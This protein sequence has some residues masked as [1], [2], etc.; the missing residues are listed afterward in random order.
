MIRPPFAGTMPHN[1]PPM[2]RALAA[3]LALA[4]LLPA[5]AFAS[6]RD[7]PASSPHATAVKVLEQLEVVGGFGDGSFRPAARVTRAEYLKMLYRSASRS[8]EQ[9]LVDDT[10]TP[11][12]TDVPEDAWYAPYVRSAYQRG[13]AH[14]V[15]DTLFAPDRGV[16]LYEAARMLVALEF[17]GIGLIE[18][19]APAGDED[20]ARAN[21]DAWVR[22]R[23]LVRA[24]LSGD[25]PLTRGDVADLLY[26]WMVVKK[27][28]SSG[29]D[30]ALD[31]KLRVVPVAVPDEQVGELESFKEAL[32]LIES[33]Y[34]DGRNFPSSGAIESGIHGVVDGLGD[35][36]SAYYT[37]QD[38]EDF[39]NQL[40][41]TDVGIGVFLTID[42][43]DSL[44]IVRVIP[45]SPADKA[46]IVAGDRIT[47]ID[48][49]VVEDD[50]LAA[51][52]Y[53]S[54]LQTEGQLVSLSLR[55]AHGGPDQ[56]RLA[57]AK[58]VQPTVEGG[59]LPDGIFAARIWEF[60]PS[61]GNEF[62]TL[63]Q[64]ADP[65]KVR[66][67]LLDLRGNPGGLVSAAWDVGTLFLPEG[68]ALAIMQNP[69]SE[70]VLTVDVTGPLYKL[71]V[72]ILVD[73]GSASAAEIV[74]AALRDNDKA[75]LAGEQ[76]Y[77]KGTVQ[78]LLPV[79]ARGVLRITVAK[80]LTPTGVSVHGV[81]LKPNLESPAPAD[82]LP[83]GPDPQRDA[84]LELLRKLLN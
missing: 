26:R 20:L 17:Q 18:T 76:T 41:A 40:S 3:L 9:N 58:V 75:V 71:P 25:A 68:S 42:E 39:L 13:I 61:T 4:T 6:F 7:V 23:N 33:N 35:P 44:L 30:R 84:G 28:G 83:D 77:G 72:V 10:S 22:D 63:L 80:W 27:T 8:T 37:G 36:F 15:S 29:Y 50:P 14:G 24:G 11:P 62:G 52:A 79:G 19:L 43:Q 47:A 53:L 16:T 60:S 45:D 51:Y 49:V 67:V 31:A 66:G 73:G 65:Q 70:S 1:P 74:A 46:G 55:R 56:V 57:L 34:I 64:K 38:T 81:G 78:A 54:G 69:R 21:L 82:L 48:G 2:R 32:D 5:T 59:L 12:F